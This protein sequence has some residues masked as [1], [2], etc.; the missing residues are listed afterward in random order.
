M[1]SGPYIVGCAWQQ[2]RVSF[3]KALYFGLGRVVIKKDLPLL[4]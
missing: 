4:P 1:A 3:E 2:A